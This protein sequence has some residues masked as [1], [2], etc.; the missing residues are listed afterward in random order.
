MP[1]S[2]TSNTGG[3]P[4]YDKVGGT[5]GGARMGPQSSSEPSPPQPDGRWPACAC[6][7][8]LRSRNL[9][10]CPVPTRSSSISFPYIAVVVPFFYPSISRLSTLDEIAQSGASKMQRLP[11]LNSSLLLSAQEPLEH[12]VACIYGTTTSQRTVRLKQP[13]R[14]SSHSTTNASNDWL[15]PPR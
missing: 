9:P 3:P 11:H 15:P 2:V 12:T 4:L 7:F 10:F 8:E 14:Q 1:H 13:G 6:P 5:G